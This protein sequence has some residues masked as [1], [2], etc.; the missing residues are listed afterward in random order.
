MKAIMNTKLIMEEG[1]IFDGVLLFDKDKI[2]KLGRS[3]D[4]EIPEGTDIIDANGLYTAPGF[5]DIHNH[6]SK[7]YWF[8]EN[9]LEVSRYFLKHGETTV[10]P[11]FYHNMSKEC[12]IESAEKIRE[13]S[14]IGAGK[15][16][17]GLYMEGPFM[18]FIGAHASQL[19]WSGSVNKEDYEDLFSNFGDMVRVWAIDPDRENI[20]SFMSYA[21]EHYPN[22]IFAHGHSLATSDSIRRVAH[23]GVRLRTHWGDS[24][25][26]KGR[27]Q[28][29]IG[30]GGD[31]F[32][33][34]EKDMYVE[35][36]VDEVGIHVTPDLVKLVIGAKGIDRVCLITDHTCP[37]KISCRNDAEAGIW[38]G[39]DLNYDDQGKLGGS[40]TTL[41]C[42]LRNVMTHTSCGL[43]AAVRMASLTPAKLL[44][45]DYRVG[46]LKPGKTAN[47]IL[48]DDT[49]KVHKVYLQGELA[50]ENGELVNGF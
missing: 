42:C 37:E 12:M 17:D 7:Q 14:K 50:A 29:T 32:A 1:I 48:M 43:C 4:I 23:Y 2:I 46:S 3:K 5:I 31:T 47:I 15:I 39:P 38:F 40:L 25:R 30:T 35:L 6:G 49:A 20:E 10:L 27:A 33:I 34:N 44:G 36:I 24:G 22:T 28:G 41:D 11:T 9:P 26:P 18:R 45:I 8:H 21:K 16:M 19:K 13:Q